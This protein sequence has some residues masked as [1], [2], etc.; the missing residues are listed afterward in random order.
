MRRALVGLAARKTYRFHVKG[1]CGVRIFK[2][3]AQSPFGTIN[4]E[5][6]SWGLGEGSFTQG[7]SDSP[8]AE[9]IGVHFG[10]SSA[11]VF[12]IPPVPG[13]IQA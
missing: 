1:L 3:C 12:I 2:I 11:I 6:F 4:L 8:E 7:A 10:L 13:N 5:Y 9:D